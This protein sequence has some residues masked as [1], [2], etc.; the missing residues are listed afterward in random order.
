[1][2]SKFIVKRTLAALA[3]SASLSAFAQ[4]NPNIQQNFQPNQNGAFQDAQNYMSGAAAASAA[5]TYQNPAAQF[6]QSSAP[7]SVFGQ[8]GWLH[9]RWHLVHGWP[10]H[11]QST[12]NPA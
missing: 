10:A 5:A 2:T 7:A 6:L 9:Q 8:T 11:W 4:Y 1:M 12:P 3:V